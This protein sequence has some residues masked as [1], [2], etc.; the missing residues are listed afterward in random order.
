MT[1]RACRYRSGT[2]LGGCFFYR[3]T[4]C[5]AAADNQ[6]MEVLFFLVVNDYECPHSVEPLRTLPIA[7]FSGKGSGI[8]RYPQVVDTEPKKFSPG[9][10]GDFKVF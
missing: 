4:R 10:R 8:C 6:A 9:R 5:C 1:T 2:E 3:K 7:M